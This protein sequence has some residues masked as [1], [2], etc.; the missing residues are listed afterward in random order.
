MPSLLNSARPL[1]GPPDGR[2]AVQK[3]I[4]R[5]LLK[6]RS[7]APAD[8]PATHAA[9]S[10]RALAVLIACGV[11]G[12]AL[13]VGVKREAI[14][15][16]VRF[17]IDAQEATDRADE[18]LREIK[19]DPATYHHA[20]TVTYTFDDYTNEYLRRAI[21]IAAANRIYRDQVP[22]AF[23]TVRY[24]RD[25]Q[26]EEYI[27]V[28]KPD[29][30]LHSV[31]HTLDEKAPGA[32]LSKEEAQARAEVFLRDRK[33]V[34]LSDWNLVET[35][36]DKKPARTDHSFEWEQKP[37]LGVAPGQSGTEGAHIRMQL[38]VQGDEVS[39][40]RIFIKIPETWRDAE[41]R[42]TPAQIAQAFGKAGLFGAALIAVLVIF[43][44]NLKSP[45]VARVPWRALGKLSVLM[46]LAGIVIYVNRA[47][48]LLHELHD[49]HAA[50]HVL[51]HSFHH[52][53]F[54][55]GGL[56][57]GRGAPAGAR[58]VFSGARVWPGT[59]SRVARMERRVFPRRVLRG[60]VWLR[61]G[62]GT[63][64]PARV[65]RALAAVAPLARR[66]RAGES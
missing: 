16:F 31:H 47:P 60:A 13:L 62:D 4:W 45:D 53:D 39:G 1:G 22:S 66:E 9:M 40:Y 15:D 26:K 61:G 64:S 57:G 51:H 38:Q 43:L 10:S 34:N 28:L 48:Q 24:F 46:L 55:H 32:N 42:T 2:G 54:H 63:Q 17:Q 20:T 18:D 35:H 49:G 12:L 29:G 36:T 7:R 27:V 11:L 37:A 58:L 25:S 14:G 19:V 3:L 56:P 21:G 6:S 33:N 8:I 65:V 44:R 50:R 41:S 59:H 52:H 5:R 30:S 23:W